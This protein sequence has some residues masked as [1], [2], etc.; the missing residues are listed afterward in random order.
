LFGSWLL[1]ASQASNLDNRGTLLELIRNTRSGNLLLYRQLLARAVL[2]LVAGAERFGT[3]LAHRFQELALALSLAIL[4][5]FALGSHAAA[6]A[7]SNWAIVGDLVHL[8][9]AGAWLGGLLVLALFL[10]QGRSASTVAAGPFLQQVVGRFSALATLNIFVVVSSGLFMS[11]VHLPTVAA[12]W[13]TTYGW[14][15]LVKI[16]LVL[17]V[18]G[19]AALNHR[20]VRVQAGQPTPWQPTPYHAFQRQVGSEAVLS[21]GLMA[22]V[23]VLVQTPPPPVAS[24]AVATTP[25]H[26]TFAVILKADDLSIHMQITPNQVGNNSYAIHLGHDDGSPIGEVQ[27]VRLQFAHQTAGQGQANLDLQARGNDLF[28]AEG[29]YFNQPGP[30]G[31]TAYV[32]RRGLD[33]LL[34]KTVVRVPEPVTVLA[35]VTDPWQNPI[36]ALPVDVVIG[37]V[38]I[39]LLVA[40]F[41]W[42]RTRFAAA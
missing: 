32:R 8:A 4:G 25:P 24:T 28:T 35:V 16:V 30:W 39:G 11:L 1:W 38:G 7:G 40:F 42:R 27:L 31:I 41:L 23:A 18:L 20:L 10:G 5:V 34:A 6:A 22:V 3:S 33:D 13:Q 9:A 17:L 26:A 14:L 12:L 29:A 36:A 2:G 15:L 21:L 19:V 37:G